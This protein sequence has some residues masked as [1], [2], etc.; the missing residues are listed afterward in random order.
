MR[1]WIP[2]I[3]ATVP[4]KP[5]P[6]PEPEPEA[7]A[8]PPVVPPVLTRDWMDAEDTSRTVGDVWVFPTIEWETPEPTASV[9]L[10]PLSPAPRNRKE[11]RAAARKRRSL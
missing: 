3:L 10:E 9:A 7:A 5:E 4:P 6:K 1:A 2:L 11:R 8:E